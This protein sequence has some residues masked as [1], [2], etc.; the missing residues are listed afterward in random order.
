MSINLTETK[1]I[2][3]GTRKTHYQPNLKMNDEVLER[4]QTCKFLGVTVDEK[5]CWK[6]HINTIK[7]KLAK[8]IGLL[9][10]MRSVLTNNSLRLLYNSLV[11]PYLSYGAELWG[12]NYKTIVDPIFLLQKKAVQIINQASFY[13]STNPIFAFLKLQKSHDIVDLN[14][15]VVMYKAYKYSLPPYLQKMF[16]HRV[17]RY[18]LRGTCLFKKSYART[19]IKRR[20][21]YKRRNIVE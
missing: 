12:N 11:L 10:K 3:F 5:L 17:S 19:H 8:N 16:N 15:L 20:C 13:A 21:L 4:V 2:I 14:T 7:S 1:F 18:N 9:G 6:S